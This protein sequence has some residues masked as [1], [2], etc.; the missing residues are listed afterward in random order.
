MHWIYAHLIG[1]YAIQLERT[2]KISP[3]NPSHE[4][5][6]SLFC[7]GSKIGKR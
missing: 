5:E 2:K 1:D 3:P 7:W 4:A 6:R